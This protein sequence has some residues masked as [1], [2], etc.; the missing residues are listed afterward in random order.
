MESITENK[1]FFY[2]IMV[3]S[4]AVVAL[5]TRFMPDLCDQFEVVPF[6]YEVRYLQFI[7]FIHILL[8]YCP[9]I[10]LFSFLL[11]SENDADN[12]CC[13]RFWSLCH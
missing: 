1:P 7:D 8:K 4:S 13:G 9:I 12:F 10:Q 6:P 5:V 11:V 2:S 3:A